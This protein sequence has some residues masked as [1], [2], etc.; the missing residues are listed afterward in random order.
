VWVDEKVNYQ[1][2]NANG[3]G[4]GAGGVGS[5]G[6]DGTG[7]GE[8]GASPFGDDVGTGAGVKVGIQGVT[9]GVALVLGVLGVE[10]LL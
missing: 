5:G 4:S 7:S 3:G 6:A 2:P 8:G 10:V 1:S 9:V